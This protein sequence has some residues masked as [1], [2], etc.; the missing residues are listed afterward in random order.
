[1]LLLYPKGSVSTK[2]EEKNTLCQ[3]G[4]YCFRGQR[5]EVSLGYSKPVLEVS[6]SPGLLVLPAPLPLKKPS[7]STLVHSTG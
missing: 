5:L 2:F 4:P 6:A 1:M 3:P 7:Q